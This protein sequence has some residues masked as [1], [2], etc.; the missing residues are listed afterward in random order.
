MQDEY[1]YLI[2]II[3]AAFLWGIGDF[4]SKLSVSALG[5]WQAAFVRSAFFLPIV[6]IYV[7]SNKDF[8][9]TVD[10]TSIYPILAGAFIGLGIILSRLS[11][12]I[13]EVSIVK[14]IQRLSILIT[15][16]LSVFFLNEK[17]GKIKAVGVAMAVAAFF[18]LYPVN[19]RLLHFTIGHIYLIGLVLALG[20]STVFLRVGILKK[21]V[22]YTRFFRSLIQTVIIFS[23]FFILYGLTSISISLNPNLIYPALNGILG[24]FAFILFCRGLENVGAS[25]AKPMMVLA[26]ITT[27]TLGVLLLNESLFLSKMIGILLAIL[28]VIFLSYRSD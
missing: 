13:Y 21:G 23:A 12:S 19:S 4:F 15:V 24:A 14:P 22:N 5:P 2:F 8:T 11:L 9:F 7:L 17:I 10:S 3:T 27:V 26:T 20:L 18:F 6:L 1:R 25:T 28:A 16:I